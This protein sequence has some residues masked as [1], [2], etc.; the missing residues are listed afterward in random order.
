MTL[1]DFKEN[2]SPVILERGYK[3]FV[4][5][6]V[7]NLEEIENGHWD[8]EVTGTDEY[9]VSVIM[10]NDEIVEWECDCPFEGEI[11]KH[12]V[13]V[14]FAVSEKQ[15]SNEKTTAGNKTPQKNKKNDINMIFEKATKED[16]RKFVVSQF[17]KRHGLKDAFI[18]QFADMLDY[19]VDSKYKIIIKNAVKSAM[20]RNGFIDYSSANALVKSIEDLLDKAEELLEGKNL[21]ESL[22][23]CKTVKVLNKNSLYKTMCIK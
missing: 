5:K 9:F 13:A 6:Q 3:Y 11:C 17:S 14:L 22:S 19:D 18:A 8:A 15:S 10:N 7:E 12:V 21:V 1:H 23:I 16:L 4:N 2:I 20:G